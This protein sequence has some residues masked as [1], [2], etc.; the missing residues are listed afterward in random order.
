MANH[1]QN[2]LRYCV[3]GVINTG[4]DFCT[5][6]TLFYGLGWPLLAANTAGFSMASVNSYFMNRTW[7]FRDGSKASAHQFARFMIVMISGLGVSSAV[8]W[9]LNH[10]MA[11][12]LAKVFAIGAGLTWN[13]C[14]M[15]LFIFGKR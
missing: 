8:I 3:V 15:T 6:M 7:T 14:G 13:Y 2:F 4:I 10:Y 9:G 5:F 12:W 11:A 1:S